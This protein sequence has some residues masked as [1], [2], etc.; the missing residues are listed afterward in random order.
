MDVADKRDQRRAKVSADDSGQ[1]R[2][3]KSTNVTLSVGLVTEAKALGINVSKAAEAGIEA[4]V[5]VGRQKRWIT[6][7]AAALASSN[8]YVEQHG[9]PLSKFRNF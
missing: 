1:G 3:R 9:L 4:A 8:T 2:G 6:E 7:N 5:A